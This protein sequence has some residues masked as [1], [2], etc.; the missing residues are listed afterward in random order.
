MLR[1]LD[2]LEDT[3]RLELDGLYRYAVRLLGDPGDAEDAVHD[4]FL[5]SMRWDGR[6]AEVVNLRAWLFRVL[7]NLCLDRLRARARRRTIIVDVDAAEVQARTA[8]GQCTPEA[9]LIAS[10]SLSRV[11]AA[12][13]ALPPEQAGTLSLI[14]VEGLT[15]AEVAWA[16]DVPVG[17]VRSRLNTARRTLRAALETKTPSQEED[18]TP[19]LRVVSQRIT[20]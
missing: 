9:A 2:E 5:R 20:K 10:D 18:T 16:M 11:A 3:F 1:S 6:P 17:T 12:M 19:T 15:Y 4:T 13:A 7:R 14:V 8:G